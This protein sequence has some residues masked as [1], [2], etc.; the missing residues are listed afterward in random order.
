MT[1]QADEIL[2]LFRN[3]GAY[4]QGHFRLTSGLHSSE[5]LQCALVLQHP[6]YAEHLGRLLGNALSGMCRDAVSVV[7]APA[8]GGLIIGHEVARV[9]SARF[10]FTERDPSG[11][12]TLRRGFTVTAG[13]IAVV[14]EDVITTGGSTQDV[15]GVLQAAGARVAAAGSIIDRSGGRANVAV[16]RTALAVVAATAWS[17][18]TCPL[19]Q[20]GVPVIKPGSRPQ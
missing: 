15:V 10:I 1:P 4:L 9:L 6:R 7:A 18:E 13:E 11:K 5:Y 16:P 8:L 12:M 17:P 3:T 14:V 2:E 20:Q 19:C